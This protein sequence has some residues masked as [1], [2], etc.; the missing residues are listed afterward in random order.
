MCA[1]QVSDNAWRC[2][3]LTGWPVRDSCNLKPHWSQQI[4]GHHGHE[5]LLHCS[6]SSWCKLACNCVF[7]WFTMHLWLPS[8][9]LVFSLSPAIEES[10]CKGVLRGVSLWWF[11]TLNRE[12]WRWRQNYCNK[13][14][15]WLC[16]LTFVTG[17]L[18]SLLLKGASQ[19]DFHL[20]LCLNFDSHVYVTGYEVAFVLTW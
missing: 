3:R 10:W 9:T 14:K 15:L 11:W 4:D 16:L 18:R 1:E 13:V 17:L 5:H 12:K 7:C 2:Y 8:C 19:W 20:I 6:S